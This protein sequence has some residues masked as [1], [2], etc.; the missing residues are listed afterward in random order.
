MDSTETLI[1]D[2]FEAA[3]ATL[4]LDVV[5]LVAHGSSDGRRMQRR[6]R[7]VQ[8]GAISLAAM[9]VAVVGIGGSSPL[10]GVLGNLGPAD[11]S[12]ATIYSIPAPLVPATRGGLLAAVVAALPPNTAVDSFSSSGDPA[13][14]TISARLSIRG[15]GGYLGELVVTARRPLPPGTAEGCDQP[16]NLLFCR[17]VLLPSGHRAFASAYTDNGGISL[18]VDALRKGVFIEEKAAGAASAHELALPPRAIAR[19]AWNPLVG[20]RTTQRMIDRGKTFARP[21]Y[22]PPITPIT[23]GPSSGVA[24]H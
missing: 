7:L 23:P 14:H 16:A 6:R 18:G 21:G 8:C 22:A 17:D 19:I 4:D 13:R 24:G 10:G 2:R 9:L 11:R 15:P 1:R 5:S 20:L 12:P 3:V